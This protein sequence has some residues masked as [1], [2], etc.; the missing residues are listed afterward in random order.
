M[1]QT[2]FIDRLFDAVNE[3]DN[4]PIQDVVTDAAEDIIKVYLTDGSVFQIQC[5]NIGY[6]W[7][8]CG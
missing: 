1:S 7:L 3:S 4:L 5:T 8:L 2:E 6:W